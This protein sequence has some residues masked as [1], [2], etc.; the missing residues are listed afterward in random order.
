MTSYVEA[1]RLMWA[2]KR[3]EAFTAGFVDS[4]RKHRLDSICRHVAALI[5]ASTVHLSIVLD[6][7]Q[8]YAGEYGL[9]PLE[10]LGAKPLPQAP[11]LLCLP[12]EFSICKHVQTTNLPVII[13]NGPEDPQYQ[14][15]AIIVNG[16]LMAYLGVPVASPDGQ[17][18]GALCAL[19]ME[20]ARHWSDDDLRTLQRFALLANAVLHSP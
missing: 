4:E 6:E 13:D 1:S 7:V 9:P 15:E 16:H 14:N 8:V 10:H 11:E 5:Q 19:D 20:H 3:E 2:K 17:S 18:I 12:L